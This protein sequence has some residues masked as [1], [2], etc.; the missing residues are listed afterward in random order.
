MLHVAGLLVALESAAA[1]P[2]TVTV[3]P[4]SCSADVASDV[5]CIEISVCRLVFMLTCCST[6]ANSTSCWVNWVV[7]SGDSGSWFCSCVVRS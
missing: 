5:C 1:L 7:S 2:F 3:L 4:T 6:D